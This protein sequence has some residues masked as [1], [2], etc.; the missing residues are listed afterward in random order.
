KREIHIAVLLPTLP[1]PLGTVFTVEVL[2]NGRKHIIEKR[3]SEFYALHKRIRKTCKVPDF[4]PKRVPNWM[5]KVQEQRRQGLE[6]Y[7]Q[8]VLFYNKELPK[9][10]LDFLKLR[11]FQ[12]DAK[13]FLKN[14]S[15]VLD[16]L[17]NIH[18]LIWK[19]D[20]GVS[21]HN[22]RYEGVP[23]QR[24]VGNHRRSA[25]VPRS[26]EAALNSCCTCAPPPK[27]DSSSGTQCLC[28]N[29]ALA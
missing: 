2:C 19:L 11:H 18:E 29:P 1:G 15:R 14:Y 16:W 22:Q 12:Q 21:Q 4:P 27:A 17:M 28:P 3:Y 13:E 6:G 7:M 23:G 26:S 10:L 25:P 20:G 8:G 9:E 24:K 5:S